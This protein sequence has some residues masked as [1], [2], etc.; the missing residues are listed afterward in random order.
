MKLHNV[1]KSQTAVV[2]ILR[3]AEERNVDATNARVKL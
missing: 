1:E 3:N 2:S